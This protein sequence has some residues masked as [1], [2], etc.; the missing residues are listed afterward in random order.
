MNNFGMGDLV[1]NSVSLPNHEAGEALDTYLR[2]CLKGPSVN[3]T[4]LA[5]RLDLHRSTLYKIRDGGGATMATITRFGALV[6]V[7]TRD[8]DTLA[9][10]KLFGV[11]DAAEAG[12]T[13]RATLLAE[14]KP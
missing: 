12:W 6:G 8:A 3:V 2:R 10:M 5:D 4:A 7:L 13:T 9:T 11:L 14:K 1:K